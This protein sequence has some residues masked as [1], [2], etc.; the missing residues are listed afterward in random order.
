MIVENDMK[1]EIARWNLDENLLHS[2]KHS[3][4][5]FMLPFLNLQ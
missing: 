2:N 4:K 3:L 1:M 5:S